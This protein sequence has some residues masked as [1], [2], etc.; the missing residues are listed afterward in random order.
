MF[1]M[2][3]RLIMDMS[4]VLQFALFDCVVFSA[5]RIHDKNIPLLPHLAWLHATSD[6]PVSGSYCV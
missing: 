2:L 3:D 5:A 4:P 6:V 1:D